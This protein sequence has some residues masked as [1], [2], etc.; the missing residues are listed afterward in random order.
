MI[1]L[2]NR[3]E[4]FDAVSAW[5]LLSIAFALILDSS[6]TFRAF[7]LSFSTVGLGFVLHEAGHKLVA[8]HMGI[9]SEFVALYPMLLLALVLSVFGFI[10]AIPGVV[11]PRQKPTSHETMLI[12]LAGPVM[13]F[14][15]AGVFFFL[16]PGV[17]GGMGFRFNALLTG[18]NMLP[19]L[20]LDGK[21]VWEEDRRVWA[22]LAVLSLLLAVATL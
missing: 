22:L 11:S 3:R 1:P 16:V 2:F 12:S 8:R 6:L 13:N 17:L 18:F 19:V 5:I 7:L 20:G 10:L 9:S 4:L 15:L 14:F 21:A